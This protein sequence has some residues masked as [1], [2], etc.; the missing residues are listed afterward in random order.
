MGHI[1]WAMKG[2]SD[3][4]AELSKC[5]FWERILSYVSCKV[6]VINLLLKY[7]FLGREFEK[8]KNRWLSSGENYSMNPQKTMCFLYL[9][10]LPKGTC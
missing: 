4:I 3:I 7:A 2:F 1:V 9:P 5:L 8:I 6:Y 10:P